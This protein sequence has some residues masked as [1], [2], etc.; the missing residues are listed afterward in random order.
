MIQSLKSEV[1]KVFK[2]SMAA[3]L[4]ARRAVVPTGRRLAGFSSEV[5]SSCTVGVVQWGGHGRC[6]RL[7]V[8]TERGQ[9]YPSYS[10]RLTIVNVTFVARAM[11][12]R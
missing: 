5:P 12:S 2:K 7:K 4:V 3:I 6:C 1:E 11:S 8:I 10:Q 9:I